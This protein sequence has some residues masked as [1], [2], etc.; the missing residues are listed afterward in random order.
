MKKGFTKE[1]I[2]KKHQTNVKSAMT[3]FSI[4][5]V[6]GAIFIVRFLIKKNTDY[7]FSLAI[8]EIII[9]FGG[10]KLWSLLAIVLYF[11]LYIFLLIRAGKNPRG[12]KACLAVYAVDTAALVGKMLAVASYTDYASE[13]V[14]VIFHLFIIVF[15]CVGIY[16]VKK[17]DGEKEV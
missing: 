10:A 7:F 17:L 11:A 8:T 4:S 13:A 15:I 16:S 2:I 12:L 5:V 9:S 3:A 1:D 14:D 6:L